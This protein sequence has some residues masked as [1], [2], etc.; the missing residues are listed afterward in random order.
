MSPR[1]T[2]QRIEDIDAWARAAHEAELS[3]REAAYRSDKVAERVAFN[4]ILYALLAIGEAAKALPA[5]LKAQSPHIDWAGISG[6]RDVLA[7]E[8][9][10][11]STSVVHDAIDRPLSD[12]LAWCEAQGQKDT[13]STPQ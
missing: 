13:S 1:S 11:I 9:F 4:A 12:L 3:L 7:H 2:Q 10:R 6:M 8:Y 5:D